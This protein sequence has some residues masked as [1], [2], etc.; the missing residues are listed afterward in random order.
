MCR[1]LGADLDQLLQE[2]A[3]AAGLGGNEVARLNRLQLISS[4]LSLRHGLSSSSLSSCSTPPRCQSLVSLVE[5]TDR[6]R[7]LPAASPSKVHHEDHSKQ[8]RPGCF[9]LNQAH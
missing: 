5:W 7:S 1:S 4:S 9:C 6:G 3:R 8:V 2:D